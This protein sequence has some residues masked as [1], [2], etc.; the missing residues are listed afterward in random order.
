VFPPNMADWIRL[1]LLRSEDTKRLNT[2]V[3]VTSVMRTRD[4]KLTRTDTL[5]G[6][7][8]TLSRLE[9]VRRQ[10][11]IFTALLGRA[12][13]LLHITEQRAPTVC[14]ESISADLLVG[15]RVYSCTNCTYLWMN[16]KVNEPPLRLPRLLLIALNHVVGSAEAVGRNPVTDRPAS[17]AVRMILDGELFRLAALFTRTRRIALHQQHDYSEGDDEDDDKDDR[18]STRPGHACPAYI[19]P[20]GT[21]K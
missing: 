10:D 4:A 1:R 12:L 14:R 7:H 5:I 6:S 19:S 17:R 3:T 2:A 15:R 16:G 20:T 11:S 9:T 18:Y 21:G 8:E 13:I